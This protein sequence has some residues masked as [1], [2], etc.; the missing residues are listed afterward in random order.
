MDE[1]KQRPTIE[2]V[3]YQ[4]GRS[5]GYNEGFSAGIKA[6]QVFIESHAGPIVIPLAD[7]NGE[8]IVPMPLSSVDPSSDEVV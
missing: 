4:R 8:L 1:H 2:I 7:R 6:A 3:E 5:D